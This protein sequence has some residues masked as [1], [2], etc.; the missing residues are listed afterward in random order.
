MQRNGRGECAELE[1]YLTTAPSADC[2]SC[3]SFHFLSHELNDTKSDLIFLK[4][5]H[6]DLEL[7][8]AA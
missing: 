8:L 1:K 3:F 7:M 5:N 4:K 6:A 2:L